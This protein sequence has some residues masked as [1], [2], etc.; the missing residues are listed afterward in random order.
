[1]ELTLMLNGGAPYQHR[2]QARAAFGRLPPRPLAALRTAS[3][4]GGQMLGRWL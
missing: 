1:M 2:S 3:S 4:I